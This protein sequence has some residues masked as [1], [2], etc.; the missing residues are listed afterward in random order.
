MFTGVEFMKCPNC[1]EK[2]SSIIRYCQKCK[3]DL[4][5]YQ[6][7]R[8]KEFERKDKSSFDIWDAIKSIIDISDYF[9]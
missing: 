3:S 6:Q 9:T 8:N 1:N 5:S 7:N 2:T 4:E